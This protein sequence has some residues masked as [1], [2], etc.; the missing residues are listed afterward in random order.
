MNR[1]A[2]LALLAV[3][4]G[5]KLASKNMIKFDPSQD[6][7]MFEEVDNE[8]AQAQRNVAQGEI[9][10]ELGLTKMVSLKMHYKDLGDNIK[11]EIQAIPN[12]KGVEDAKNSKKF[13]KEFEDIRA[14]IKTLTQVIPKIEKLENELELLDA[15]SNGKDVELNDIPSQVEAEIAKSKEAIKKKQQAEKKKTDDESQKLR[16]EEYAYTPKQGFDWDNVEGAVGDVL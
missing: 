2:I 7:K 14:E 1:I 5:K 10:R 12:T 15:A 6:Q 4:S 13:D 8:L 11:K 16:D 3:V 9:G